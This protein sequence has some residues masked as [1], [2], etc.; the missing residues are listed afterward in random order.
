M[1]VNTGTA[2]LEDMPAHLQVQ[3][4]DGQELTDGK[5]E[6]TDADVDFIGRSYK[7]PLFKRLS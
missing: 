3:Y 2:R 6:F 7:T 1:H 4:T 5:E